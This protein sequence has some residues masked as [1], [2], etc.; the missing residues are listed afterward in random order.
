VFTSRYIASVADKD[1]DGVKANAKAIADVTKARTSQAC[2][3][4]AITS[5]SASSV[6]NC[7]FLSGALGVGTI[8]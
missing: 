3:V 4:V 6:L 1:A 5:A 8:L 2:A 7:P